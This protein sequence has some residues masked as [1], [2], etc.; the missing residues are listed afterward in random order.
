MERIIHQNENG[1]IV[2]KP[3]EKL[4]GLYIALVDE[5]GTPLAKYSFNAEK[6]NNVHGIAYRSSNV[7]ISFEG[8]TPTVKCELC[9]SQ[10]P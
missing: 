2:L 8:I 9:P 6:L 7:R 10:F 4:N 1:K 3:E 5:K